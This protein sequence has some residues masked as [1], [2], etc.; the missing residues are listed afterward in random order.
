[1]PS[2][3]PVTYHDVRATLT[4]VTKKGF[5]PPIYHDLRFERRLNVFL[6]KH[7]GG[8][9]AAMYAMHP[10][11]DFIDQGVATRFADF[12]QPP[13]GNY[14]IYADSVKS[15]DPVSALQFAFF[16]KHI[17]CSTLTAQL[18]VQIGS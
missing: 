8:M 5:L 13:V 6:R 4:V 10:P 3:I 2:A 9:S 1:M 14:E 16:A 17:D 15:L 18:A 7:N 12:V 11:F